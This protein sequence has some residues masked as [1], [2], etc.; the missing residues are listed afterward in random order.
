[1]P[2]VDGHEMIHRLRLW[3]QQNGR[4][5][6]P[7]VAMTAHSDLEQSGLEK[8]HWDSVLQ[9]PFSYLKLLSVVRTYLGPVTK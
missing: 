4:A 9:K 8:I 2:N 1:M 6:T 5:A 3:E 7:V